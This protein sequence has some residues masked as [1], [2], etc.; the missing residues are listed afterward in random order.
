MNLKI[1][2]CHQCGKFFILL[3]DVAKHCITCSST[4]I[5]I[6]TDTYKY[7]LYNTKNQLLV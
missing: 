6:D 4:N 7:R 3:D 5:K 2:K 1:Y